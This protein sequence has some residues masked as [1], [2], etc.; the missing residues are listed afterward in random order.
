KLD[1]C[2]KQPHPRMAREQMMTLH[3]K[4]L[5]HQ[6]KFKVMLGCISQHGNH[7]LVVTSGSQVEKRQQP[8]RHHEGLALSD[9]PGNRRTPREGG[10][11]ADVPQGMPL[12][13][14]FAF[15][16]CTGA[17]RDELKIAA[18]YEGVA[19]KCDRRSEDQETCR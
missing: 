6:S 16:V 3:I 11:C 13:F 17:R 19:F 4:V 2:E 7:S 14:A 1:H 10:P 8:G 18:A 15:V 5:L 9:A 12:V